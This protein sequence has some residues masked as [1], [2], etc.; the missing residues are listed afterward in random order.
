V[1]LLS[2]QVGLPRH[3]HWQ[4]RTVTTGIF[5]ERV[6]GPVM[7]RTLNLDG[8][9]QADLSVHGGPT[10]AV[11]AYPVEH[12]EH[13]RRE[14]PSINLPHGMFGENFTIE[15]LL[16]TDVNIVLVQ[17]RQFVVQTSY[18]S[19]QRIVELYRFDAPRWVISAMAWLACVIDKPRRD[20]ARQRCRCWYL[21]RLVV[22]QL[23]PCYVEAHELV[24]AKVK[25]RLCL[26]EDP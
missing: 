8:D 13:W 14:F 21:S 10:R 25:R 20:V 5:K 23:L 9:A 11:Y 15:G 16:E 24:L 1:K 3:V 22:C 4:G 6:E 17:F 12:Y 7:L 19:F 18:V 26:L 2:I